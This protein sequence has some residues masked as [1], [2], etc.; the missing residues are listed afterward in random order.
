ME[1]RTIMET[2]MEGREE[3]RLAMMGRATANDPADV[4]STQQSAEEAE[5]GD[6][7]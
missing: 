7:S 5:H 1:D 3:K 4:Q 2:I 6:R